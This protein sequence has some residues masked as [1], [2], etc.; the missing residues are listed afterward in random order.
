[1]WFYDSP[2]EFAGVL[3]EKP[4]ALYEIFST[5]LAQGGVEN[6]FRVGEF[7]AEPMEVNDEAMAIRIK[8]PKPVDMPLCFGAVAFFNKDFSKLRFF[9]LEKGEDIEGIFPVLCAWDENGEHFSYGTTSPDP[10]EQFVQCVDMYVGSKEK[11]GR[12]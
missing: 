3:S 2:K 8:Y 7:K 12:E 6:T 5:L 9:T 10:D 4:E 1:M 11:A